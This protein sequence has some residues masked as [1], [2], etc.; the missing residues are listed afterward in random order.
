MFSASGGEARGGAFDTQGES[1][2]AGTPKGKF[3]KKVEHTTNRSKS[4]QSFLCIL[5]DAFK[6][7]FTWF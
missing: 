7:G 5:V 3:E 6:F 4:S 1:R 2:E